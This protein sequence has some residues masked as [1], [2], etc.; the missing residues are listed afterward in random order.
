MKSPPAVGEIM[1]NDNLYNRTNTLKLN[2]TIFLSGGVS[3][4]THTVAQSLQGDSHSSPQGRPRLPFSL[5]T[6]PASQ[7][8]K[9]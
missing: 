2:S 5:L 8:Q 9:E 6:G 4:V 3:Y 1:S 7:L